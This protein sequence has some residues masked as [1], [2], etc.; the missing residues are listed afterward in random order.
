MHN[1]NTSRFLPLNRFYRETGIL[2]FIWKYV[3]GPLNLL[4][5]FVPLVVLNAAQILG[6]LIWPFSQ[7]WFRRYQRSIAYTVWAWW[8][9]AAQKICG[10]RVIVTGDQLPSDENAVVICNHQEMSDII[11]IL[12]HAYNIGTVTRTTWMAKNVLKYVPGLGWGMAFLDTVFLK[13]NWSR[14]AAGIN[15]T[16]EKVTKNKLPIWMI[17]FPEGTRS[18]PAKLAKSR[19][20]ARLRGVEPMK[21]LLIPRT[22]GFVATIAG[23]RS[24]VQAVYSFTIG[25]PGKVP[26]L[27]GIIRG[28]VK[29]VG[30]H[31]RRIPIDEIP[32]DKEAAAW[33][34]SEFR[35]KDAL[36]DQFT[37]TGSFSGE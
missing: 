15:A 24:H 35:I 26:T 6:V 12:C 27:T 13:R 11:V 1:E 33:L 16:F 31:V 19:E 21:H 23:L 28:D 2:N 36:L 22:T 14:D 32:L 25:Y 20:Y 18:T 4:L 7:R 17:S 8:G 29:E 9:F 30:L 37:K 5:S 3:W 34:V 10:L